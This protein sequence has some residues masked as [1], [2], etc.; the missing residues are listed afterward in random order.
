MSVLI[1]RRD[2]TFRPLLPPA[3]QRVEY[4]YRTSEYE[5]PYANLSDIQFSTGDTVKVWSKLINNPQSTEMAFGFV[6]VSDYAIELY[7]QSGTK[8]LS[9]WSRP[10]GGVINAVSTPGTID[11]ISFEMA[12]AMQPDF[13]GL[14]RTGAY[15]ADVNLYGMRITG[16]NSAVKHDLIPC[17]RNADSVLGFY[18]RITDV[19]YPNAAGTGAWVAG[20]NVYE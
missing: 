9:L 2:T 6:S 7:Y 4:L 1:A 18:D 17:R 15:F 16:S 11:E 5:G 20:A 14:Y 13:F 12:S 19:F 10:S 8:K 3:Y